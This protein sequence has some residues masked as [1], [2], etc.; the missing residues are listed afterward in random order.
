VIPS[1]DLVVVA[2]AP[3]SRTKGTI[4][5]GPSWDD[6]EFLRPIVQSLTET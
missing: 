3:T 2:T 4:N 5:P 1:L 6:A